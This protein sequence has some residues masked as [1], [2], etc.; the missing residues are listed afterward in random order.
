MEYDEFSI[1]VVKDFNKIGLFFHSVKYPIS[2]SIETN[3]DYFTEEITGEKFY[4][5]S[6][7]E[8]RIEFVQLSFL[9]KKID[10]TDR[11]KSIRN[12]TTLDYE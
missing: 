12:R 1:F 2:I 6:D 11:I 3:I 8:D 4:K 10:I 5:I 7:S 9:N